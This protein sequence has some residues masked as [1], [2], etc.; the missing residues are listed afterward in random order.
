[1]QTVDLS[2][3]IGCRSKT[4]GFATNDER[5]MFKKLI[6][7]NGVGPKLAVCILSGLPV[8]ELRNAISNGDVKLISSI[9]G[10]GKKTAER[11]I[12]DMKESLN[13]FM[14]ND[15]SAESDLNSSDLKLRDAIL[16]LTAL[17][18][19]NDAAIKMVKNITSLVTADMSVEEIIRQSLKK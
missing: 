13:Q 2:S 7:V 19:S 1:M 11:M 9:S 6:T 12:V 16:A 5:E 18:H 4:F 10:I 15:S 8:H 17:G 3:Y 14:L